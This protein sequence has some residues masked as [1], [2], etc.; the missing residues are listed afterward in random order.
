MRQ[1]SLLT[2]A[3][4][5]KEQETTKKKRYAKKTAKLTILENQFQEPD[6]TEQGES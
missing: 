1:C 5:K 2:R 6:V 3:E 4:L